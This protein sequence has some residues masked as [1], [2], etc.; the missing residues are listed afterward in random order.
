MQEYGDHFVLPW[1]SGARSQ[2]IQFREACRDG[3]DMAG[4]SVIK[5]DSFSA[6]VALT[7]SGE[8]T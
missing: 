3:V 2:H 1:I 6:S 5:D 8:A 4:M 7:D